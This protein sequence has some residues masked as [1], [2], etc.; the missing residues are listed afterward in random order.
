MDMM[1]FGSLTFSHSPLFI[2]WF[3][4]LQ[5]RTCQICTRH[6]WIRHLASSNSAKVSPTTTV[7]AC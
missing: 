1:L 7:S 3:I 2:P 4:H 5:H 6:C